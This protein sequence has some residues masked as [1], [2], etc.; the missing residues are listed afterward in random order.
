MGVTKRHI[1]R[2]CEREL[3]LMESLLE[4]YLILP[5]PDNIIIQGNRNDSLN[6]FAREYQKYSKAPNYQEEIIRWVQMFKDCSTMPFAKFKEMLN[7]EHLQL[8]EAK[9]YLL[10]SK[11]YTLQGTETHSY[12]T[13]TFHSCNNRKYLQLIQGQMNLHSD[14]HL[15]P[16]GE[17]VR[18]PQHS[19]HVS[20]PPRTVSQHLQPVLSHY[21]EYQ[22][23]VYT[24]LVARPQ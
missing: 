22:H 10:Y 7:H 21:K 15:P 11:A 1:Q 12:K 20:A 17:L 6:I 19:Q 23:G 13:R 14:Q 16:P 4:Y 24:N 3:S 18:D 9:L 8:D 2:I 5:L